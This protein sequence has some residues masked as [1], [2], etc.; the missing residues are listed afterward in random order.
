MPD[1]TEPKVALV[2]DYLIQ[3]G[4]AEATLAAIHDIFPQAPV[5]TTFFKKEAFPE[6]FSTWDIRETSIT[7][8]PFF[9]KLS[10]QY[11]FLYP[12][13]FEELDLREF[14]IVISSS[15][16]WGKGVLTKPSQL[17]ITYCHT[18]PRF[19]YKYK[20]ESSK[21]DAFYYKPFVMLIDSFLRVW[22]YSSAHRPDFIIANSKEVQRRI[23]KFYGRESE[24]IYPPVKLPQEVILTEDQQKFDTD[25]YLIVSRLAAYKNIEFVVEAFNKLN[26]PLRIAGEGKE[27][28]RLKSL[29]RGNIAFLGRVDDREK[30]ILYQNCKGVINSV[31]EE[32]FGIVPLEALSFGKPVLAHRSGGH[33]ET[34]I[35]GKSGMFFDSYETESLVASIQAFDASVMANSYDST[36][37]K[38]FASQFSEEA[39]KERL[40]TFVMQKWQGMVESRHAGASRS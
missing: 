15:S 4:G 35:E 2:H 9:K 38:S 3:N 14:D 26:L 17:H 27:L 36:F 29:V 5:Y 33:L 32:D 39:F 1:M 30:A 31:E 37:M 19:L 25:Y 34:I 16:S 28:D 21:R 13:M 23:K 6:S 10:K 22:D 11:T 8:F 7:K 12:L 24:V 18:P 20:G 40:K